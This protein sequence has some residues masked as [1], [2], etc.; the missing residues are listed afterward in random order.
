MNSQRLQLSYPCQWT[1][2]IIGVDA[3]CMRDAVRAIVNDLPVTI[4]ES[5]ASR[6]GRYVSL[7]VHVVVPGEEERVRLFGLLGRHESI[8][9]VL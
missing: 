3:A 4:D 7:K 2:T 6:G 1:Y 8:K 5:N 9:M